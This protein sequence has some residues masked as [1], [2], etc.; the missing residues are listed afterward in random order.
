MLVFNGD[1]SGLGRRNIRDLMTVRAAQ[2]S[3]VKTVHYGRGFPDGSAVK[4]LPAL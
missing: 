1:S 4:N 3:M 2:L